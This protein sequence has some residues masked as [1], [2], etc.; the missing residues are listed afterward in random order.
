MATSTTDSLVW[1]IGETAGKVWHVLK[2]GGKMSMTRL[3]RSVD[4]PRDL[5]LQAIGWLAREEKIEIEQSSKGR[6]V[7]LR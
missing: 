7:W 5:V 1:K 3:I 6:Y 2:D 4:A